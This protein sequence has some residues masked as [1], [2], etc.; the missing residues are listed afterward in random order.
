MITAADVLLL[1]NKVAK[2]IDT[3]EPTLVVSDND[4][5]V[6]REIIAELPAVFDGIA[7][8]ELPSAEHIARVAI[9]SC[10]DIQF[11]DFLMGMFTEYD[12]NTVGSW[13]EVI[14]NSVESKYAYPATTVLATYYYREGNKE[15]AILAI[16]EVLNHKPNYSLAQLLTRVFPVA[17]DDMFNQMAS[18]LH[19]RVKATIFEED[20][21]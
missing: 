3:L 20:N 7:N 16:A 9:T 18:A 10:K 2:T 6:A 21:N 8:G 17:G 14:N 13:L 19:P 11:R 12:S 1:R 4:H 15:D 5:T